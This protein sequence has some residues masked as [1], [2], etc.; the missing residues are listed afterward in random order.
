[1]IGR[2]GSSAGIDCPSSVGDLCSDGLIDWRWRPLNSN[3][4]GWSCSRRNNTCN[5]QWDELSNDAENWRPIYELESVHR[6]DNGLEVIDLGMYDNRQYAAVQATTGKIFH[7]FSLK[8]GRKPSYPTDIECTS[9][10]ERMT[11]RCNWKIGLQSFLPWAKSTTSLKYR[12]VNFEYMMYSDEA[13]QKFSFDENDV[14]RTC[15]KDCT[16]GNVGCCEFKVC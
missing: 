6:T 16:E 11:M 4:W 10:I 8:V 3:G 2:V 15:D 5:W 13:V 1:V 7:I 12:R 9:L 14:L